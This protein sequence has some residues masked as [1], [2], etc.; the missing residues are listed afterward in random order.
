MVLQSRRGWAVDTQNIDLLN[1][2]SF[3]SG[4]PNSNPF[5]CVVTPVFFFGRCSQSGISTGTLDK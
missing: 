1:V 5:G 2:L 3:P 4:S